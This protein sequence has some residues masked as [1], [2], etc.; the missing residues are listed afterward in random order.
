MRI[1]AV[2]TKIRFA[3]LSVCMALF[4]L[5]AAGQ[6]DPQ[7]EKGFRPEKMYSFGSLDHVNTFNGNLV[8][9]IPVGM[10][11]P[12]DGGLTYGLSLTYNSKVWDFEDLDGYQRSSPGRR[13]NA[14]MG[15]LLTM[16]RLVDPN[17]PSNPMD[18]GWV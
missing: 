5:P 17:D 9:A 2:R 10:R 13:G 12:L 16:G 6:Q 7:E 11:Y 14:G 1:S 18:G 4:T 15:W 3:A 8:A